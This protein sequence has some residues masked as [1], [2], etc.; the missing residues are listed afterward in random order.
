MNSLF[1]FILIFIVLL[2]TPSFSADA[3]LIEKKIS[4]SNGSTITQVTQN[5][6]TPTPNASPTAPDNTSQI[7]KLH[8][9]L[10]LK[11]GLTLNLLIDTTAK[12]FIDSCVGMISAFAST[13]VP[14]GWLLCD[15][16]PYS[17]TSNCEFQTLGDAIRTNWGGTGTYTSGHF[18]GIFKVPDLR[19]MFLRGADSMHA[20][21][22]NQPDGLSLSGI[23]SDK[24]F[25][26]TF[27]TNATNIVGSYQHDAYLIHGATHI[28]S[29]NTEEGHSHTLNT[30]PGSYDYGAN[31]DSWGPG[32]NYWFRSSEFYL[33]DSLPDKSHSH[34]ITIP[35]GSNLSDTSTTNSDTTSHP[36]NYAVV[37][38]IRF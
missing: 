27:L 23:D 2:S 34:T 16:T 7:M 11:N 5:T 36:K 10:L 12:S 25:G 32:P 15:G 31:R 4:F 19:G 17:T 33:T 30:V 28:L 24:R 3:Y 38:G 20:N 35:N 14:P 22:S 21:G 18:V 37:Y 29:T 13:T 9:E 1:K 8:G 6:L 26:P